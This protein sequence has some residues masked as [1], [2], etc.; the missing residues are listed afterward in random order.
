V[1]EEG[2]YERQ[3]AV[4]VVE[5]GPSVSLIEMKNFFLGN[6]EMI[7]N[8]EIDMGSVSLN[9]SQHVQGLLV[10]EEIQQVIQSHDRIT[11]LLFINFA[12]MVPKRSLQNSPA[13]G[14]LSGKNGFCDLCRK[15]QIIRPAVL[16]PTEK[17]IP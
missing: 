4:D 11:H 13:I 8:V 5:R 12:G 17:D 10:I 7:E 16:L 9:S 6:Y 15:F 14:N 3:K 2:V 1:H